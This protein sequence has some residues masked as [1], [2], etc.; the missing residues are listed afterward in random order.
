MSNTTSLEQLQQY[1]AI[2]ADTGDI[3]AI[4]KFKP[5]DATTNPSLL[6]KASELDTY[7]SYLEQAKTFANGDISLACD[8]FATLIGKEITQTIDGVISTEIDARLSFN[9]Q[10]TVERGR[11]LIKLYEDIGVSNERVLLKIA[12]TW[13]GIQAAKVFEQEGIACNITLLFCLEQAKAAADVKATLISPFVGRITDW[14]KAHEGVEAYAAED[15]PGVQSVK[16]IYD[17]YKST[18]FNTIVMGASFRNIEQ[19]KALSGCDKLTISPA[20]LEEL[21][22]SD[23]PVAKELSPDLAV[24]TA[25]PISEAE[26]RLALNNNNMANEKLAQGIQA[27]IKDQETLEAKMS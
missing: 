18:G 17:Y 23:A 8:K 25:E 14:Y 24:Q 22:Q 3:D 1:T 27:F 9:T 11:R 13:E 5:L 12:A 19:V 16:T 20:L 6:L 21:S 7:Q 4:K 15:D 2:V 10:A 26:F